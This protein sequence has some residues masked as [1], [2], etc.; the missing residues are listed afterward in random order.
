MAILSTNVRTILGIALFLVLAIPI[1][2]VGFLA[3]SKHYCWET[4]TFNSTAAIL[5]LVLEGQLPSITVY[6]V[7]ANGTTIAAAVAAGK[8]PTVW[9]DVVAYPSVEQFT[10]LSNSQR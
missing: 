4:K 8:Y 6:K 10:A 2:S 1:G 7:D 3:T 9:T 5:Q